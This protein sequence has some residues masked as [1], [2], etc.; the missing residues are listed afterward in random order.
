MRDRESQTVSPL[1]GYSVEHLLW[2]HRPFW[3]EISVGH[4][5]FSMPDVGDRE[6]QTVPALWCFVEFLCVL[7]IGIYR[8]ESSAYIGV[9]QHNENFSDH[10][11]PCLRIQHVV[12][13]SLIPDILSS[14]LNKNKMTDRPGVFRCRVLDVFRFKDKYNF[15]NPPFIWCIF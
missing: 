15:R 2:C 13:V 14:V 10:Q 11:T 6:P 4:Q 5:R 3:H 8:T 7:P 1:L 9:W 12:E